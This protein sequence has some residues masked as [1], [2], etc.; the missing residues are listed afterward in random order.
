MHYLLLL[1]VVYVA[2]I[3]ADDANIPTKIINVHSI[4][5][6][7]FEDRST[8][9]EPTTYLSSKTAQH[10]VHILDNFGK[11][12]KLKYNSKHGDHIN[13]FELKA[14][15][16]NNIK[17]VQ[18]IND[19]KN[20]IKI[21][22]TDQNTANKYDTDIK[23]HID[24]QE[25]NEF[26]V[27]GS[28]LWK[29][30]NKQEK[31]YTPIIRKITSSNVTEN[32]LLLTT[33]YATYTDIFEQ[34]QMKL[35]TNANMRPIHDTQQ[36]TQP[37]QK[38]QSRRRLCSKDNNNRVLLGCDDTPTSTNW[39]LSVINGVKAW[40]DALT[41]LISNI[42]RF[43]ET[44]ED[45]YYY[46]SELTDALSSGVYDGKT[47]YISTS[48]DYNYDAKK[49]R[50]ARS[51]E[52]SSSLTC[53]NCYAFADLTYYFHIN[54]DNY[55]LSY[56]YLKA[57]G[58]IKLHVY[59]KASNPISDEFSV[60]TCGVGVPGL[61]FNIVGVHFGFSLYGEFSVSVDIETPLTYSFSLYGTLQRGIK[62]DADKN[63]QH[64]FGDHSFS[65]SFSGPTLGFDS[66]EISVHARATLYLVLS[67]IGNVYI[68]IQPQTVVSLTDSSHYGS[69]SGCAIHYTPSV[70]AQVF[71]G[72]TIN[73]ANMYNIWSKKAFLAEYKLNVGS[74]GCIT[75][76]DIT[77]L[78]EWANDEN[79]CYYGYLCTKYRRRMLP[80]DPATSLTQFMVNYT[81][82]KTIYDFDYQWGKYNTIW[83][84]NLTTLNKTCHDWYHS[85]Y[86]F[87]AI[88]FNAALPSYG[89][90]MIYPQDNDGN[91]LYGIYKTVNEISFEDGYLITTNVTCISRYQFIKVIDHDDES[92][93]S[94]HHRFNVSLVDNDYYCD[95]N[96][97]VFLANNGLKIDEWH[98]QTQLPKQMDATLM[99][100]SF[101]TIILT[102]IDNCHIFPLT[103]NEKLY[104]FNSYFMDKITQPREQNT[105]YK[106]PSQ[107]WF[108]SF[109]CDYNDEGHTD[110]LHI[111]DAMTLYFHAMDWINGKLNATLL[112]N[113]NETASAIGTV[114]YDNDD[115]ILDFNVFN[116]YNSEFILNLHGFITVLEDGSLLYFGVIPSDIHECT[117][118][119]FRGMVDM[120]QFNEDDDKI[121]DTECKNND[122][123]D[124]GLI[125]V[126]F[127]FVGLGIAA[128]LLFCIY[129]IIKCKGYSLSISQPIDM[130]NTYQLMNDNNL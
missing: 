45:I 9:F 37:E 126:T 17:S 118:F 30:Y 98:I 94:M 69:G 46:A 43:V 102:D 76:D 16:K 130:K 57:D 33:K 47:N 91:I 74:S 114:N 100:S 20:T 22:F 122:N 85:H 3:T 95:V 67:L 61:S 66:T 18:C 10:N 117:G 41:S 23:N 40:L 60:K 19:T 107:T 86:D 6:L 113:G 56:F 73:L 83:H 127:M 59:I 109:H 53:K 77:N 121:M 93:S 103:K 68:G 80:N 87:D 12:L 55:K 101:G 25:K 62:Y 50:A 110:D 89:Y 119:I 58:N 92:Q 129:I 36:D 71:V 26:Y 5:A 88:P 84:A 70:T 32:E 21:K 99:D 116:S 2:C 54:I 8:L 7:S 34:L 104:D 15:L 108:G 81:S 14:N 78:N 123:T 111:S 27:T 72:A 112:F 64:Y 52:L 4:N 31:K 128:L 125:A 51:L 35:E 13:I 65:S 106:L 97:S 24:S 38:I 79:D 105:S 44:V 28:A 63:I 48:W 29:C 39:L 1:F 75:Y 49:N 96:E 42:E 124:N 120:E 115:L 82:A 90:L 11:F